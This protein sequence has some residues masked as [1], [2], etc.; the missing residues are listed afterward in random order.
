MT[1]LVHTVGHH[2]KLSSEALRG[3]SLGTVFGQL[4]LVFVA[5]GRLLGDGGTAEGLE[6]L[7][8]D[9]HTSHLSL[10]QYI[11]TSNTDF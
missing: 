8:D 11:F 7:C 1:H 3:V 10:T 5:D 6:G 9:P 4:A 2:S